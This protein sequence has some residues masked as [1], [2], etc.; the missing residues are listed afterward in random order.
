MDDQNIENGF[1]KKQKILLKESEPCNL[2]IKKPFL[3]LPNIN[4]K[5]LI[6]KINHCP[7]NYLFTKTNINR[8]LLE[9]E[10]ENENFLEK[11]AQKDIEKNIRITYERKLKEDF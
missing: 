11:N 7:K 8:M 5:Q 3:K 2:N 1:L 9:E 4:K 6:F 10:K